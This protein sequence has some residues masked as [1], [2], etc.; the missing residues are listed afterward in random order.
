MRLGGRAV[1]Y[2]A[3]TLQVR[4]S[5]LGLGKLSSAFRPFSGSIN[6]YQDCLGTKHF[7]HLI[8]TSAHAP[9][10][11]KLTYTEMGC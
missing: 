6:E 7:N 9:Q 2:G 5:M 11:P 1:V 4:G 8:G 10:R 3:S